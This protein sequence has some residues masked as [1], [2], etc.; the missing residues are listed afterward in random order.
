[1]ENPFS[2]EGDDRGSDPGRREIGYS[3]IA[4]KLIRD[5]LWLT[6]LELHAELVENGRE[7][8]QLKEF[9]S[10]PVNFE[11][12]SRL[13]FLPGMPRSSSQATLDS[14]DMTRYVPIEV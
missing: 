14:L 8:R 4:A 1:M 7:V 3:D 9:F 10:N 6:A 12:Q 11:N 2:Q 5:K 13:E